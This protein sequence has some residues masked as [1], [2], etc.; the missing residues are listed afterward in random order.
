VRLSGGKVSGTVLYCFG[1]SRRFEEVNDEKALRGKMPGL[2]IWGR[3][4]VVQSAAEWKSEE[5]VDSR[6]IR[7]AHT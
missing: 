2:R 5:K 6:R 7:S 1:W 4:F 3:W